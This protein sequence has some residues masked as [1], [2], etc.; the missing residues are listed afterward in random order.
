MFHSEIYRSYDIRGIVPTDLD[1]E[2]AY[3]IGRAFVQYSG[4]RRIVVARDMR[5]S[6][7]D[8]EPALIRGLTEGGAD[9]LR[10]GL[11][12]SPLFYFAVHALEADGGVMVTASHNPGA[13]N[14]MKM[15]RESAIPIAGDTGLMDIRD[16]VQRRNWD[17]I[18]QQGQV[19]DADV[20]EKY[21]A[22]VTRGVSAE[23]LKIVV[24]AGNGM[25]GMLLASVFERI[26]GEVV[27]LYWDLDGTFPNHEADPLKEENMHDLHARVLAEG[28][29][30]GVAFDGDA[31]RVFFGTEKGV[32][33]PGDITTAIIASEVLKDHPATPV[34]F[35][36]RASRTTAEAIREAGGQPVMWKVGHSLIKPKMREVGAW[37][38]G[39]VSGH[40]FFA[41]HYTESALRAMG[42]FLRV[43][44]QKQG[45]AVS[46]VVAPY[47][48]YAKT[49]EINFDVQD[50]E[51]AL[52]RIRERYQDAEVS[53]LDGIRVDY[54]A[55]WAN[56]RPSN[57]EP[58]L[59][60]N[61][62]ADTP[63][64]LSQKQSEIEQLITG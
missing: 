43:L 4:A 19:I 64:L 2:E 18:S 45:V 39:E 38:A 48:R 20:R 59:R 52:T 35:D 60:L 29:D 9:V 54:P 23:G 8:L 26:G 33:I 13:Y 25:A 32:T 3:H 53:E 14:G 22:E 28:A 27:P 55:W 42:Y 6:G 24:D 46:E 31:D 44:Q 17:M 36:V 51:A 47:L 12:T 30:F 50:K 15:T 62:E 58:K 21:V 63:E 57:T 61:M 16:L 10:V 41:P 5:P 34:I 37:F 40:Y 1:A 56:V 49:P 11:A 7:D